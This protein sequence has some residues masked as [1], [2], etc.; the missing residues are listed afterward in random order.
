MTNK[1]RMLFAFSAVAVAATALPAFGSDTDP[2][3][4]SVPFAF[5]AGKTSLPAG[6]YVMV[7]DTSGVL[8]IKGSQGSAMLLT[9]AGSDTGSEKAGV[10]FVRNEQG[11]VLTSVH[12]WGRITSSVL[13]VAPAQEK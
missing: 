6:D 2:M 1:F 11:Y 8:T 12:G 3:R 10:R 7:E 9:S 4:I 5:K 13:P